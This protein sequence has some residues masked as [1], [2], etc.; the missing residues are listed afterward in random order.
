MAAPSAYPSDRA[1]DD[2]TLT[3]REKTAWLTFVTMVM[4]YALYF[5]LV[6]SGHPAAN[7]LFPMLWLFGT[8]ATIHALVVVTGWTAMTLMTPKA[9]RVPV[10]ERDRAIKRRGA[11]AAYYVMMAG[12]ILVGVI[13]PFT[14]T[15]VKIANTALLA[16]VIAEAVNRG[17]V[18][19]SYRRGWHG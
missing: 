15:P 3:L 10:D 17:I 13:M 12:M 5:G 7:A 18:L 2:S 1:S 16:I 6:A 11:S 8:I 9:E 19:L 14:D 4:A